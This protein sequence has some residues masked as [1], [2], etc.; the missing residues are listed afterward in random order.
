M[1]RSFGMAP[2]G[3]YSSRRN[4]RRRSSQSRCA[5]QRMPAKADALPSV[6]QRKVIKTNPA[7]AKAECLFADGTSILVSNFVASFIRAGIM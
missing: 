1:D 2:D 7:G 6:C 3:C 4:G 5:T